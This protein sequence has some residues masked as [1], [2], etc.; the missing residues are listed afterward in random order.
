MNLKKLNRQPPSG[1]SIEG[2]FK[3]TLAVKKVG[4]GLIIKRHNKSSFTFWMFHDDVASFLQDFIP[5][6]LLKNPY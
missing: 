2:I 6:I 5:S 3:C 1:A 4:D